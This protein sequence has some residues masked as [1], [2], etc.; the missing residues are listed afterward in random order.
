MAA[1]LL[2]AFS[3][4]MAETAEYS[5]E[6]VFE[7]DTF[8]ASEQSLLITGRTEST[9]QSWWDC[10]TEDN[11]NNPQNLLFRFWSDDTGAA[12]NRYFD[13][14]VSQS[15]VTLKF[16]DSQTTL[17]L[18]SLEEDSFQAADNFGNTLDCIW[19][20]AGRNSTTLGPALVFNDGVDNLQNMLLPAGSQSSAYG[21]T[22]D[23]AANAVS[24]TSV[25]LNEDRSGSFNG[26]AMTWSVTERNYLVMSLEGSSIT[27]HNLS[28]KNS[29]GAFTANWEQYSVQCTSE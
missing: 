4:S 11:A 16:E 26:E 14:S 1:P 25:L 7:D 15:A 21:C 19:Q 22:V 29:D 6:Q 5:P 27:W 9:S 2:F 28:R 18:E 10:R 12:G 20:G 24:A 23:D 8:I 13:W 3:A 17:T